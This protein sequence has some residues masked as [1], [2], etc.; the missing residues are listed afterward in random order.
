M[1]CVR[2]KDAQMSLKEGRENDKL[3]AHVTAEWVMNR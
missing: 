1:V 3:R 2:G